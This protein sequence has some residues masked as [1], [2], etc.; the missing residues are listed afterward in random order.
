MKRLAPGRAEVKSCSNGTLPSFTTLV[1]PGFVV[2]LSIEGVKYSA[3]A[4]G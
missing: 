3:T 1:E 2:V 4:I